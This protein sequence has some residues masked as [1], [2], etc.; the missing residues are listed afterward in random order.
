MRTKRQ[1]RELKEYR[2][3]IQKALAGE[4]KQVIIDKNPIT[5]HPTPNLQTAELEVLKSN[6]LLFPSFE[7]SIEG[8]S[9][10]SPFPIS[11][12]ISYFFRHPNQT[13][14]GNNMLYTS[15]LQTT[16]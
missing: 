11:P 16:R 3:I 10:P 13:R 9:N 6:S 14:H 4:V 1:D 12:L 5:S 8:F 2:K 7:M 15:K